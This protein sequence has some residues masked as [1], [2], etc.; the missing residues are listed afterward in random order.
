V[1]ATAEGS[2]GSATRPRRSLH[3]GRP[4]VFVPDAY[5]PIDRAAVVMFGFICGIFQATGRFPR[6]GDAWTYWTADLDHLYPERW[7][8]DG[9][10]IYPPPLAQLTTL[11]QPIGWGVFITLWT[12]LLWVAL[13]YML[14]RWTWLFVAAGIF[15]IPFGYGLPAEVSD[16][17][18]HSLNG[19]VQLL[20]AAGLVVA[21]RGRTAGWLPGLVTK[22][23]SGLGL[24]WYV[25]RLEW[26]PLARTLAIAAA[27]CAVSF[28]FAP[29]QWFEWLDWTI[30][31]AG[32]PAPVVVEPIPFFVRF[33][34]CLA[35]LLWG[36]RTDR[37][38][39]VPIVVGFGT[40]ALYIGTYPSMWVAAIPLYLDRRARLRSERAAGATGAAGTAAAG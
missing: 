3:L 27:V 38:W 7:G 36:A 12:T 33:P 20:I 13:A 24:G 9:L 26:A 10:Y 28:A 1:T 37:A 25:F 23:V 35:L 15:A 19:N 22:V 16:V 6:P 29:S 31:N 32:T 21:M 30:R 11:L 17:L 4:H 39:V 40:P 14:G 18:G 5:S 2:P 34:A 8:I